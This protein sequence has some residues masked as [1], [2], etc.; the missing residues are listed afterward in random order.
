MLRSQGVLSKWK[1]SF[2]RKELMDH[3]IVVD[4]FNLLCF[5]CMDRLKDGCSDTEFNIQN[6]CKGRKVRRVGK[7]A[8]IGRAQMLYLSAATLL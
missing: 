2:Y 8:G 5:S 4:V 3:L 7:G 6:D 1:L